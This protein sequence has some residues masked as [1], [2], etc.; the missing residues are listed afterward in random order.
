MVLIEYL[1]K[2]E[3][4]MPFERKRASLAL[5]SEMKEQLEEIARSRTE[6]AARVER[7]RIVLAY[8][9]G[10]TVSAIARNLGTNRPKVER[11][12]DKALQMGAVAALS[13]MAGRG[14]KPRISTEARAWVVSLACQKP[15]DLG[16]SYELWTTRLLS[17]HIRKNCKTAGFPE[18]VRLSRGTVS[19]ILSKMEIRPH[20]ISYYLER[21][22]PEF[23]QK[24]AQVL[25]VYREVEMLKYQKGGQGSLVAVL[26]YDE[27]PGIQ[28]IGNTAD[29]LPPVPGKHPNIGRDHEYVRHGTVTL[30]AAIDL[31]TGQVHGMVVDRHRSREFISFLR[32]LDQTYPPEKSIR[33]VLDNHSAHIS[34]E[35]RA[36]L[37]TKPNRF[38]FIFTPKHGSWLNL[39]EAF[40]GKLAR[41]MLRG[42]RVS[43]KQELKDRLMLF[44]KE[45]NE[46][47]VVFRWRTAAENIRL[48]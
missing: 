8:A 46:E 31:I 19:K 3:N 13:D 28:A 44:L 29:D 34:K 32:T 12:I 24:M 1:L 17:K 36:F 25:C 43:S 22:D 2:E 39:I 11:C 47:P 18:L 21:R 30:M 14:R 15:K 38:E 5:V 27:K 45:V 6:P 20:K 35:T 7:A 26:S 40:F 42:I 37:A 10:D 33:M 4:R 9:R 41:T 48:T 16:Y 23:D